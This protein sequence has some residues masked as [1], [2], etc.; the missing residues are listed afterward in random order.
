MSVWIRAF[1]VLLVPLFLSTAWAEDPSAESV[2]QPA[3]PVS[4]E[5]VPEPVEERQKELVGAGSAE[6]EAAPRSRRRRSAH[7]DFDELLNR[8]DAA[9]RA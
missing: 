2:T 8:D 1:F 4:T 3:D 7:D 6:A 9:S 5:A